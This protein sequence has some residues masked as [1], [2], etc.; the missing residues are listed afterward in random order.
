MQNNLW[1]WL[2][3]KHNIFFKRNEKSECKSTVCWGLNAT[4]LAKGKHL[5]ITLT[6]ACF[7]RIQCLVVVAYE[8]H[9]CQN[10]WSHESV[11]FSNPNMSNVKVVER[12][13]TSTPP[14]R[15]RNCHCIKQFGCRVKQI[16]PNVKEGTR[17]QTR[18]WS[19]SIIAYEYD[20][21]YVCLLSTN[22]GGICPSTKEKKMLETSRL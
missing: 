6:V 10:Q 9:T 2:Q 19:L 13:V 18:V 14:F 7:W 11:F 15:R 16:W 21:W 4:N 1:L 20:V 5:D 17:K 12:L 22:F 3:F 8:L